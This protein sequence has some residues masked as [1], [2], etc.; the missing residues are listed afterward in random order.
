MA[1]GRGH[2][3][4][5]LFGEHAA[6]YGHPALG[7]Q[8]DEYLEVE[9][10]PGSSTEWT[11][12]PLEPHEA[13]L[14]RSA[15]A[16]LPGAASP[17]VLRIRGTLP[18]SV[19]FGSSAAFCTALL[20]ASGSAGDE[21][22]LWEAAHRLERIFH[23]TPSG[24]D[25][26]LSIYP[27]ASILYPNPPALPERAATQLPDAWILFGAIPRTRSTAELVGGIRELRERDPER[28]EASL[29]RLGDLT[30]LA[31]SGDA[32]PDADT[33]GRLANE[34]HTILALLDLSTSELER[35]LDAIREA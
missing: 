23:G 33:L 24:I 26:G 8:L 16:A 30:R 13:G 10:E 9:L 28:V 27:G 15:L 22:T 19:G 11:L 1:V 34:A 32:C 35:V 6:V 3:K 25:T 14:V 29:A 7:I 21:R 18:M 20:R 2:G 4:L 5:L 31:A 12:P 17:G